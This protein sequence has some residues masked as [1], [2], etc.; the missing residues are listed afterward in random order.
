MDQL[1]TG[2]PE[3]KGSGLQIARVN[4]EARAALG[5]PF[6]IK[7]R[8][9]FEPASALIESF[10]A[11]CSESLIPLDHYLGMKGDRF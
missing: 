10:L 8:D 7:S 3:E 11:D 4:Q 9:R 2:R 1:E 5:Q 6:V